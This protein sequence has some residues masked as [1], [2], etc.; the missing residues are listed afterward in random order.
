MREPLDM[1]NASHILFLDISLTSISVALLCCL[2]TVRK[3]I[4][5]N[6]FVSFMLF[7]LFFWDK[8][9][10]AFKANGVNPHQLYWLRQ[11]V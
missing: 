4:T 6:S 11:E 2:R 3:S 5:A 8:H 10:N 7:L 1:T 9:Q